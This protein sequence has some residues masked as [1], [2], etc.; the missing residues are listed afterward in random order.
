MFGGTLKL[1]ESPSLK[2]LL[3][4]PKHPETF[5]LPFPGFRRRFREI[6][7]SCRVSSRSFRKVYVWRALGR[8]VMAGSS[9]RC[10]NERDSWRVSLIST[11]IP[12]TLDLLFFFW[13]GVKMKQLLVG[14]RGGSRKLFGKRRNGNWLFCSSRF[15][16]LPSLKL[17]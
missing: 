17:T 5:S 8:D 4:I 12:F 6:S 13:G 15:L 16:E 11:Y 3:R 7:E 9:G 10:P 2:L 1:Y 14:K